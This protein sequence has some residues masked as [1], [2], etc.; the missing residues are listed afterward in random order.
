MNEVN[1]D[2]LVVPKLPL[3]NVLGLAKLRVF[4]ILV[5]F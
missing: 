3:G 5:I 4:R 2:D 1:I